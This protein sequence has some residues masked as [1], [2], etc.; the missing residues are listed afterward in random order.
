MNEYQS[1]L[2]LRLQEKAAQAH[3]EYIDAMFAF[4]KSNSDPQLKQVMEQK[5][6]KLQMA[7]DQFQSNFPKSTI[8]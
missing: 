4:G 8:W 7:I 1:E 3:R 5:S 6:S 2:F